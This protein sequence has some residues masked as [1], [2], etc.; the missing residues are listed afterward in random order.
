VNQI[1]SHVK[2]IDIVKIKIEII[3]WKTKIK[4]VFYFSFSVRVLSIPTGR[5]FILVFLLDLLVY[6]QG[7]F[8]TTLIHIRANTVTYYNFSPVTIRDWH[9]LP[10]DILSAKLVPS[11]QKC[12]NKLTDRRLF[13]LYRA[14]RKPQGGVYHNMW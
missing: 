10:K 6:Q 9:S 1:T 12:S 14:V 8:N 3:K 13:Q 5:Y 2:F 7:A 4:Y 11:F